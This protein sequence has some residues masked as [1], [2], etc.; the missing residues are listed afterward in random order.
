MKHWIGSW[1]IGV[2]L[3]HTVFAMIVF[4]SVLLTVIQRGVFNAVGTDPKIGAV[5]WFVLFGNALFICGV[6]VLALERGSAAIPRSLGW[7]LLVLTILGVVLM[8]SSG[9]WL[10][11]PPAIAL[12]LR[13]NVNS[14]GAL[15]AATQSA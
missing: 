10:A 8:P 14:A 13:K 6:A 9:F 12:V 3:L 11:F 1:I 15:R 5:V 2:S 7:S 4:K